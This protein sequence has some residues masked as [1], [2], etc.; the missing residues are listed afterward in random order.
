V[1]Q[2][3]SAAFISKAGIGKSRLIKLLKKEKYVYYVTDITPKFLVSDFLVEMEKGTYKFICIGD[4]TN[5]TDSHS[6]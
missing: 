4:F 6:K 5:V 2:F 3:Q 1:N